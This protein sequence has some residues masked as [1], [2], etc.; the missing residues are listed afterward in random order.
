MLSEELADENWP[1][2]I[3]AVK[4][5]FARVATKKSAILKSFEKWVIFPNKF[6]EV[7]AICANLHGEITTS[8]RKVSPYKFPQYTQT[9]SQQTQAEATKKLARFAKQ[10]LK[11]FRNCLE[12]SL[13]TPV[14][15]EAFINM[16]VL[17]LC[18]E[19]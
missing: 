14:L 12:L 17:I 6:V 16:A 9:E 1:S 3:L 13:I 15:A 10:S 5:D 2:L 7:A 11:L 19:E 18:K 8:I 4:A